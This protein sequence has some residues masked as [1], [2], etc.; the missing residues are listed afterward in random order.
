MKKGLLLLGVMA[1][2]AMAGNVRVAIAANM[3]YAMEALQQRFETLYPQTKLEVMIGSSGKLAAQASRGAPYDLF[4]SANMKYPQRL[5]ESGIA[6]TKPVVYA[7]GALA[8]LCRKKCDLSKGLALLQE[9]CISKIAIANPKTAPYGAAAVEALKKA[10]LYTV[11]KTKF[12]YGESISQTVTY[13][14]KIADAGLIAKS[15]LFS[16]AMRRFKKD[17]DWVDVDTKL[18]RPIAQGMVVLKHGKGNSEVQCLYDFLQSRE[19]EKILHAYGY[20]VGTQEAEQD[21]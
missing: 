12:V 11:V 2:M 7:E 5:F 13:A 21:E 17:R 18:Y 3:S 19:A 1:S 16:T 10:N 4:L 15:A 8:L 20:R 6:V 9:A 14:T